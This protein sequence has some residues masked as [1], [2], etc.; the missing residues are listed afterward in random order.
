M[1]H[2]HRVNVIDKLGTEV[3]PEVRGS[4]PQVLMWI[5][6]TPTEL[7]LQTFEVVEEC[8][9][10]LPNVRPTQRNKGMPPF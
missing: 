10:R 2:H 1:A 9:E 4:Q 8:P 7:P 6:H 5:L 3:L